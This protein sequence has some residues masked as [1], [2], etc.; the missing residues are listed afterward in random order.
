ITTP[1]PEIPT[2]TSTPPISGTAQAGADEVAGAGER[3]V[4]TQSDGANGE[5]EVAGEKTQEGKI[6]GASAS[7][8]K[9]EK[10]FIANW[11][12][13]LIILILLL[14]LIALYYFVLRNKDEL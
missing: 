7:K 13:W 2:A 1:I 5:E 3:D 4:S 10:I 11:W 9:T 6:N 12:M 8:N 14:I